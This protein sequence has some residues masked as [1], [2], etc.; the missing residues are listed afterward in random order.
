MSVLTVT[1]DS[2]TSVIDAPGIVMLDFWAEWC[3][4]CRAFTPVFH[5]AAED[6]TDITFGSVD[7]DA[8]TS[9]AAGLE[10]SSIPTIMAFRDG[11]LV[12]SQ[13]GALR[14]PDFARVIE[15]VRALDMDEVRS[16]TAVSP[17]N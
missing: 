3:P 6:N 5:K 1:A 10:I 2:F 12:F 7:T 4:P 8:E 17:S 9:L 15:A 14:A 13:P 16:K 11:I